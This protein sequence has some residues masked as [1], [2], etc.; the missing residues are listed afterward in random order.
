V[1]A[2]DGNRVTRT[3]PAGAVTTLNAF[4]GSSATCL[5]VDRSGTFLYVAQGSEILRWP[6]DGS[7]LP[8][9]FVGRPNSATWADGP[10]ADARFRSVGSMTVDVSGNLLVVDAPGSTARIRRVTPAGVVSTLAT[11]QTTATDRDAYYGPSSTIYFGGTVL[12]LAADDAGNVYVANT[13]QHTIERIDASGRVTVLA[14]HPR[15]LG[16][17]TGALPGSLYFPTGI[18]A[19]A[20]GS[21]L[22]VMDEGALLRIRRP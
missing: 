21:D 15:R 11:L 13:M 2:M 7:S 14:G 4:L 19:S 9:N 3:T 17:V 12:R 18:A 10:A 6:L 5:A 8:T 22:F 1:Y 20:D 16:V